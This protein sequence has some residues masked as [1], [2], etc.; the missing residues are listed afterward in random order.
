[1]VTE[2]KQCEAEA[3]PIASIAI[4]KDPSVPFLN[5]TEDYK[6]LILAWGPSWDE[7]VDPNSLGIDIPEANSR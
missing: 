7:G 4:C 1:M 3:D 2:R 6:N 5:P